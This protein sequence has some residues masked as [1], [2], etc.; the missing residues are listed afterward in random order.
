[1]CLYWAQLVFIPLAMAVYLTFL[2]DPAV[3]FLRKKGVPR[4]PAVL[5]VM[6][7]A[8][9]ILG[10]LI[11]MVTAQISSLVE[12]LPRYSKNVQA[13]VKTVNDRL[14]RINRTF[15]SLTGTP[16]DPDGN[17]ELQQP[18]EPR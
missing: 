1:A 17:G 14:D 15:N 6:L 9:L 13:K 7:L 8:S 3:T 12:H 5:G 2:L 18:D 16:A 11:W 4:V 10:A